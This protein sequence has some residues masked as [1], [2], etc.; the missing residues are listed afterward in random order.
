[1]AQTLDFYIDVDAGSLLPQGAAASGI[2]P[3]LTRN[4][5]YTLRT[6]LRQKDALGNLR[7]Y[8]TTGVAVKFAIG[9]IDDGPSS[10]QFR[11]A[12]NGVTSTAITYNSDES[13][14]A[15]NIY[16]AVS[17]NVSTVTT[18]GLEEDSYILTATQ[19]NTALSFSGDAFTLFPSSSV[20]ISTR[21]NPTTGVNAQQIIK[22]RRSSAVYADS[23]S[24]SPTAGIISLTKVQD[25]SSSPVANETYRLVVGNDAEGGSFVLNYGTNSTTGIPIGTTAV[26]FTEAL[27]SVTGIGVSNISVESGNSSGEYVISFVRGL[28][29]TNLT[30]TLSLDASGVIFANFLQAS[31]TMGTAEL[32][33]LFAETGE[34][35]ITPTLEIEVSETS[36][37]K[38]VYQGAITVRRDLIQVGDAVPGAQASYYTK[39]EAD[40][41][42]VED[43]STGAAGSVDATNS[44]LKDTSATDSVDWQNRKL[45]D[46]STEYLRWDNGLGF[47]GSSAVAKP[48]G[49]NLV[50][51]VSS[52]GLLS[53]STPTGANVVSNLVSAGIFSSSATYGVLPSTTKTLTTTVSIYFGQV[54]SNT[55]NS[56]SVVVTGCGINDI[57]LVG[58]PPT[59]NNGLAFSGHVTTANG[60]EL[61]CINATN[62]NITPATATYRITVIGY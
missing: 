38:T 39:S 19:S 22:L 53:Y 26:C 7:D 3:E 14:T 34:S 32:D 49:V 5:I 47:F 27:T 30:T 35:T 57:V 50:N 1:M 62:G 20:Q 16:A 40:A 55:T 33:E 56:V 36:K 60:M 24:Q 45:F 28:G 21:R 23:F 52:L 4:D 8:D 12:I 29:A 54:N 59:I 15:L 31:V 18:Y 48:S 25:G 44:K 17:N 46:G 37:K 61:D 10:G 11:L 41:F 51:S 13:A 6:R 43:A 9:N 42:F 58:L 2:L